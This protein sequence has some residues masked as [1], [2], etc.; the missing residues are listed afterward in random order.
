MQI[1]TPTPAN[2][3][4][5]RKPPTEEQK[6]AEKA[7]RRAWKA[8]NP[9]KVRE[10]ARA[11]RAR[12]RE[13]RAAYE[14]KRRHGLLAT[15]PTSTRAAA[16]ESRTKLLNADAIYAAAFKAVPKTLPT[17]IRDVIISDLYVAVMEERI[18]LCDI[19]RQTPHF[20]L[21][22]WREYGHMGKVSLDELRYADG[23]RTRLDDLTYDDDPFALN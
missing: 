19:A 18:G 15:M 3:S 6:A 5:I 21:N 22:Y 9:E 23:K 4:K 20:V 11:Y 14:R 13:Q 1:I 12:H 16:V 17:D 7:R 10:Q 8:N 2:K